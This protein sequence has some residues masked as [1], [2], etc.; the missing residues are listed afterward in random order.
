MVDDPAGLADRPVPSFG[1]IEIVLSDHVVDETLGEWDSGFD[2]VT[3]FGVPACGDHRR[4]VLTGGKC[5][6]AKVEVDA[7]LG[8]ELEDANAAF[9]PGGSASKVRVTVRP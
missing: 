2:G 6:V 5:G 3:E 7:C 8:V 1:L 9:S 4:G